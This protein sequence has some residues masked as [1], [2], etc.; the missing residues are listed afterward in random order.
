MMYMRITINQIRNFCFA[1]GLLLVASA[2][3]DV[4][5]QSFEREAPIVQNPFK[6]DEIEVKVYPNPT[7]DFVIVSN[8]KKL[9]GRFKL[10]NLFGKTLLEGE[11]N[12]ERE[13][14]DLLDFRTGIYII[15]LYD[16]NGQ[17]LATRKII[18]N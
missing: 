7:S 8:N 3:N 16:K 14:I 12:D 18:K 2:G 1:I 4:L 5:S 11:I 10:N 15:S 13:K 9:E 6:T 17:K